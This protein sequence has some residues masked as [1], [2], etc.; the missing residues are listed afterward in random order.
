MADHVAAELQEGLRAVAESYEA[1]FANAGD[2]HSL[3]S[4]NARFVGPQGQLTRLMKLMPRI[5]A[6]DRKAFGLRANQLKTEIQRLF[7]ARLLELAGEARRRELGAPSMD[8]SLPGRG[9][10]P[11]RLHP[12]TRVSFEVLDVFG[13]LGFDIVDGPEVEYHRYNFDML[14]FPMDH[15]ATDQQDS[16]FV[17]GRSG[18]PDSILL[19][20]HT[21]NMQVRQ[22]LDRS[23]PL[24]IVAPGTV[25]R[26]DDDATHSPMFKQVE[27]FMVSEQVSFAHL[28]GTLTMF[29]QRMFGAGVPVRFRPSYF[30]FVEPGGE[31][32]MGC[33]FCGASGCRVCKGTGWIEILGCGMI[34]PVVF[35]SVGYDPDRVTGFA[36]GMGI[37]RI[38]MLRYG[39]AN[40]RL[41]YENDPR[42]LAQF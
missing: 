24:A 1:V 18:E 14:G 39:I 17:E 5:E 3:R 2:E 10:M 41:L 30:P 26:R 9:T 7:R 42:F 8:I 16:F 11:G 20:T 25:Y 12:L 33:M 19:R 15:P 28:K 34:H 37:D 35:E 23:P 38:A 6:G 13:V 27:G 22:M 29:T 32:D 21:S 4:V 36:F 40:I 31:M